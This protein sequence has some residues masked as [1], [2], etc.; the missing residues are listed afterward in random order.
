MA[1]DL[2]QL[3]SIQNLVNTCIGVGILSKPY[4]IGINGWYS[5][6]TILMAISLSVYSALAIAK[7]TMKALNISVDEKEYMDESPNDIHDTGIY[8]CIFHQ[9]AMILK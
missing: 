4:I 1:K 5:I 9:F 8:I 6:I 2:T 7:T 3:G